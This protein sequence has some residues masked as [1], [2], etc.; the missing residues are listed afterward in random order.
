MDA[1]GYSGQHW[2]VNRRISKQYTSVD[3]SGRESLKLGVR[4]SLVQIQSSR[5]ITAVIILGLDE[6][7]QPRY[8]VNITLILG[9]RLPENVQFG[10]KNGMTRSVGGDWGPQILRKSQKS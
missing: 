6:T 2:N 5:P 10:R 9:A 8:K 1:S 3:V 4:G 7:T